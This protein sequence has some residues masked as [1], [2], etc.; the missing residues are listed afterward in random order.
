MSELYKPPPVNKNL[1]FF[2]GKEKKIITVNKVK[3]IGVM[4]Y[5]INWCQYSRIKLSEPQAPP[6]YGDKGGL[7]PLVTLFWNT[8]S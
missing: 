4:K 2:N 3:K 1:V 5:S 8:T 6:L 7:L